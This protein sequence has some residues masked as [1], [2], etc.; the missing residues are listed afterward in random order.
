MNQ[1]RSLQARDKAKI[2]YRNGIVIFVAAFTTLSFC[3][4]F[5]SKINF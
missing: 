5:L 1:N 3:L 2:F 4:W